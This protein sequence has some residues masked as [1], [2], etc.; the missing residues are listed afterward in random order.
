MALRTAAELGV[1]PRVERGVFR[2]GNFAD[3][4]F[5]LLL[6]NMGPPGLEEVVVAWRLASCWTAVWVNEAIQSV[7]AK[8]LDEDVLVLIGVFSLVVEWILEEWRL[9]GTVVA[10][11]LSFGDAD[12]LPPVTSV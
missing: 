8:A 10:G 3:W 6:E 2:V 12:A 7:L 9:V 5:A 11:V 4:H 1:F